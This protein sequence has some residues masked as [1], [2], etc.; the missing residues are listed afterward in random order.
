MNEVDNLSVVVYN[1]CMDAKHWMQESLEAAWKRRQRWNR[2]TGRKWRIGEH[3][4]LD[5]G[6]RLMPCHAH[7][8][9]PNGKRSRKCVSNWEFWDRNDISDH[10]KMPYSVECE[11]ET[12]CPTI[13]DAVLLIADQ[14]TSITA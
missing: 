7:H 3:M 9:L 5:A 14:R 2:V 4:D 10:Y 13:P 11:D 12:V 8:M 1:V 6:F